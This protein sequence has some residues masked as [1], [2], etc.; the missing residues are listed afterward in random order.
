MPRKTRRTSSRNRTTRNRNGR[1][2]EGAID[3]RTRSEDRA[4]SGQTGGSPPRLRINITKTGSKVR[5]WFVDQRNFT[6]AQSRGYD[7]PG[8][9]KANL[10]DFIKTIQAD[11]FETFDHT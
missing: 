2:N 8:A 10:I 7:T 6:V 4:E 11:D 1:L 9:A 3:I 5:F